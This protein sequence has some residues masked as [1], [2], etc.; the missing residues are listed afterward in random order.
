VSATHRPERW[1]PD[2]PYRPRPIRFD[3]VRE[4]GDWRIKL[5]SIAYHA[6][7]MPDASF[8]EAWRIAQDQLPEPA[9][10]NGRPGIGFAIRHRGLGMDYFVLAWWDRENELPLRVFVREQSGGAAWRVARGGESVCVWDIQ[11]I[12]F[13]RDAWVATMLSAEPDPAAYLTLAWSTES[14]A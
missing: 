11:V 6:A 13:E 2:Q 12:A 3:G 10:A 1:K 14:P 5:Y 7:P 4:I 9:R 8:D